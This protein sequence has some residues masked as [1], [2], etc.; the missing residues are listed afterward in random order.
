MSDLSQEAIHEI[1]HRHALGQSVRSITR[2][3]HHSRRAVQRALEE[4]AAGRQQGSPHS[5]MPRR[6]APRGSALDAYEEAIGGFLQ[7]YPNITVVRLLEELRAL[8]YQGGYSVLRIRVKKLRGARSAP[9]VQRFETAPGMQAQ[10]D[11]AVYTI[12]FSAE[13]PRRVNL[14]SYV[15]GYSRRQYLQFTESQDFE[16]LLREHVRA[17]EHLGGVAATCLYDNMKTVVDRWEGGEPVYNARFLAFATH[18]GFRPRACWPRRPQ[19]KGKVER[20]FSYVELNLL[21]GRTF[22]TLEH[23]CETTKHWLAN[24]ADV[25]LHRETRKRPIDAH[26]EELAHLLPLPAAAYDTARFVYRT[27]DVEGMIAYER[28][29][30]SAPWKLVGR[31]LLV[32]VTEEELIIYDSSSLEVVARHPLVP[33]HMKGERREDASHRPARNPQE[34]EEALRGR[35]D[36]LG[37]TALRFL[38]GLLRTHRDGKCQARKV[39]SLLSMYQRDDVLAAFERAVRYHAFSWNSLERILAAQARPRPPLD[40]LNDQ[41]RPSVSDDMPVGPRPTADYQELLEDHDDGQPP[42]EDQ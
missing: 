6:R 15:L 17:F 40:L 22:S 37:E 28:N 8:G 20:R 19:T 30:Y 21:N 14:F 25:R 27:V 41:Y 26:A 2:A 1:I 34:Q 39:L 5:E 12:D 4:H 32:R 24:T 16:T 29:F 31:M 18:Y 11:W 36:E 23:L 10:M 9:L 13:G 7:R 3:M 35:F 42:E 33:R 38:E